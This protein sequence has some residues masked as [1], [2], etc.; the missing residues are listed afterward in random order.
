[1]KSTKLFGRHLVQAG[2]VT[3]EQVLEALDLQRRAVP[4]IGVIAVERGALSVADVLRVLDSQI[5]TRLPFV[6]QAVELG[7]LAPERG[8]ALLV[9]QRRATP[10]IGEIL[11]AQGV[12]DRQTLARELREFLA[13]R[14]R[15]AA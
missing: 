1:M 14:E 6:R 12:I 13:S 15:S 8:E 11:V 3:S 4:L 10:P 9:E 5:E 7:L 2:L